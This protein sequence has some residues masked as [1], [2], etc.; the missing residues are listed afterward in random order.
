MPVQAITKVLHDV[1]DEYPAQLKSEIFAALGDISYIEVWSQEVL[2]A[3]FVQAAK[4]GSLIVPGSQQAEDKWQS[5]AFLIIKLG[6]RAAAAAKQHGIPLPAVG[7]W[8]YGAPQEC[9]HLS[10]RGTGS[11]MWREKDRDGETRQLRDWEGWPCRLVMI[12][13]I[14]GRTTRPQDIM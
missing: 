4:R 5:K 12:G 1:K 10:I 8:C 14:K 9:Q 6:E 13:D 3:P 11:K 2:V 7:D